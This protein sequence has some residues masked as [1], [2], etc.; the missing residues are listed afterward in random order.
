MFV[1]YMYS[2]MMYLNMVIY[3]CNHSA[4]ETNAEGLQVKWAI[5]QD[6]LKNNKIQT[7]KCL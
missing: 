7:Q 5:K 3:I 2:N 4:E 6:P 1:L